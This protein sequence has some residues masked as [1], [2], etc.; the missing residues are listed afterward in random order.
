M[1][2]NYS[3]QFLGVC[4]MHICKK[5]KKSRRNFGW[6]LFSTFFLFNY[7]QIEILVLLT[8]CLLLVENL[9][10]FF[11]HFV[12]C[13]KKNQ[14]VGQVTP[15]IKKKYF[16]FLTSFLTSSNLESGYPVYNSIMNADCND[17]SLLHAAE[18]SKQMLPFE[19]PSSQ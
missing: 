12:I 16:T 11:L 1:L 18:F 19:Q 10:V 15:I 14:V 2:N 4:S 17:T 6:V 5:K 8:L 9:V 13:R 3:V 7:Y